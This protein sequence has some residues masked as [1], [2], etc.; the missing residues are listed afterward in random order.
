MEFWIEFPILGGRKMW[1]FGQ[2]V[3]SVHMH[4]FRRL[5]VSTF[6]YRRNVWKNNKKIIKLAW[7]SLGTLTVRENHRIVWTVCL[8]VVLWSHSL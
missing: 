7:V 8:S 6:M 4:E 3:C 1:H 5:K 2:H